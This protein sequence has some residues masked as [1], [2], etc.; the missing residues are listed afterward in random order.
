MDYHTQ[1]KRAQSPTHSAQ[2]QRRK[3]YRHATAANNTLSPPLCR[4][5]KK[6]HQADTA[7]ARQRSPLN[8]ETS[9]EPNRKGAEAIQKP[10]LQLFD[11]ERRQMKLTGY[12]FPP[13]NR[14]SK[15]SPRETTT[16]ARIH[17]THPLS[18][19]RILSEHR[20]SVHAPRTRSS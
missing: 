16:G 4:R 1:N 6:N 15:P 12:T 2:V 17:P 10:A 18:S 3:N 11:K 9:S 8:S 13:R 7:H 19:L 20:N 14:P 5:Q